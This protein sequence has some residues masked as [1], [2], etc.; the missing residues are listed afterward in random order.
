MEA[1]RKQRAA[2]VPWAAPGPCQPGH[3]LGNPAV[4]WPWCQL[5]VAMPSYFPLWVERVVSGQAEPEHG[6]YPSPPHLSG[7]SPALS[8]PTPP[9]P[10]VLDRLNPGRTRHSGRRGSAGRGEAARWHRRASYRVFPGSSAPLPIAPQ[11][12]QAWLGLLSH[13]TTP[14]RRLG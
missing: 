7:P 4:H 1:G 11:P 3:C 14:F 13:L 12:P 2:H 10:A 5:T 9:P 6:W 8:C